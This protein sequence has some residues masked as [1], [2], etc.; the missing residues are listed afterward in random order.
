MILH[1]DN[2]LDLKIMNVFLAILIKPIL[3]QTLVFLV[4]IIIM[5]MIHYSFAKNV[6]IAAVVVLDQ[7]IINVLRVR[8]IFI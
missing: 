2:V 8:L 6:M 1:V 5:A 7:M 3:V 4:K